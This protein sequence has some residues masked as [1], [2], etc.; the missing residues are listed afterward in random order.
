MSTMNVTS[1]SALT[2]AVYPE[3]V[4]GTLGLSASLG[5][6]TRIVSPIVAGFLMQAAGAYAPG[7]LGGGIMLGLSAFIWLWVLS[8]PDLSCPEPANV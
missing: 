8:V 1:N 5:R 6:L 7:L 3:Q 4:G 2:K